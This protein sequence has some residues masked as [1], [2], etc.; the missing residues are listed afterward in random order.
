[1]TSARSAGGTAALK[2]SRASFVGNVLAAR[3]L[4][5]RRTVER[6]GKPDDPDEWGRFTPPTVNAGYNP[7]R[8]FIT[9]PAGRKTFGDWWVV[10]STL[11][12]VT[13]GG[14]KLMGDSRG[15]EPVPGSDGCITDSF[16]GFVS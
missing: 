9:F 11:P 7:N 8:N 4:N 13:V 2:I 6:I 1:M 3:E 14:G 10:S 12:G 15:C 5:F 16:S